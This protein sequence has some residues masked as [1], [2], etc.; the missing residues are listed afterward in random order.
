M[1]LENTH[2]TQGLSSLLATSWQWISPT[3]LVKVRPQTLVDRDGWSGLVSRGNKPF[4]APIIP[5]YKINRSI[6]QEHL[7]SHVPRENVQYTNFLNKSTRNHVQQKIIKTRRH[8][9]L[10]H[11]I[12]QRSQRS[13]LRQLTQNQC[14]SIS[15]YSPGVLF[16]D[17]RTLIKDQGVMTNQIVCPHLQ[18]QHNSP[19]PR[20][21]PQHQPPQFS[22]NQTTNK[23]YVSN[24]GNLASM[25][26]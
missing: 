23:I 13:L 20:P 16:Q 2:E 11:Q 18:S 10:R 9:V 14:H 5:I 6:K 24:F 12:K 26:P 15:P 25:N 4:L 21:Q 22:E 1:R 17:P 8:L 3:G 7:G 19:M